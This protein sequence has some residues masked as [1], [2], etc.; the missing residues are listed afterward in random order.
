MYL[1]CRWGWAGHRYSDLL[2]SMKVLHTD[3]TTSSVVCF[4]HNLPF[5]ALGLVLTKGWRM[6]YHEQK[7]ERS[8]LTTLAF[9]QFARR[10]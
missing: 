3:I 1:D 9:R 5:A 7:P 6:L 10:G 2:A 4:N 8:S